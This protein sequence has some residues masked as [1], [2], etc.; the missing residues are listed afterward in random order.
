M[1]LGAISASPLAAAWIA[2]ASSS[3]P[4]SLSRKPRAP[5]LSAPWTY[6][7][8]S[9]V[10]MTTTASGSSTSGPASARVASMP[11]SS[12]IRMSN[13]HTSGRSSRARA[14]ASRPSAASPTTSMSGWASRIIA[15]PGADDLLVVGDEHADGHRARPCPRQ[16]RV[17]RPAP[18]GPGAGL[19]GAAEQRGP[20]GHADEPVA[21][22][23]ARTR[24]PA[25]PSSR[26][27]SRTASLARRRPARRSGWR[28]ARAA[29]RW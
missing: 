24:G 13:R 3:G 26:T 15:Q 25:S 20:L 23:D 29:A 2:W 9:N 18:V 14:T 1:T 5:A 6:S 21:R 27:V 19:E 4:A 16:H 17:D 12:G 11:S 10:V 8:R 22:S 28:G 7:S